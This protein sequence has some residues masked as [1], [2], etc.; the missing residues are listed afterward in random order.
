M[1]CI[2]E[3]SH[4][5]NLIGAKTR[6]V[7]GWDLTDIT[8]GQWNPPNNFFEPC[9]NGEN[10]FGFKG[11]API[12]SIKTKLKGC[13]TGRLKFGGCHHSGFVRVYL[14]GTEI[15]RANAF[16]KKEIMFDFNHDSELKLDEASTSIIQFIEFQVL[17]CKECPGNS[18]YSW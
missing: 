18:K 5:N 14:D 15:D 16:E 3:N 13:G 2:S 7:Q 11:G 6:T 9:G 12:G 8:S 17:N 10:W 1:N 4:V